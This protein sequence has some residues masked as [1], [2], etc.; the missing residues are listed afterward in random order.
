MEKLN[1][2]KIILLNNLLTLY[3][4]K[5]FDA[6][7][8]VCFSNEFSY[9]Y[10]KDIIT[11]TLAIFDTNAKSFR[12]FWLRNGYLYNDD[13]FILSFFHELGHYMTGDELTEEEENTSIWVKQYISTREEITDELRE[14]YYNLPDEK[15]ATCWAID[16]VN[17]H[18]NE[19]TELWKEIEKLVIDFYNDNNVRAGA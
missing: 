19:I 18:R 17:T 9:S 8:K 4:N 10:L 15:L 5:Y 11:Y 13:I 16:Y 7:I 6:D 2:D 1:F 3:C 14:L 12:E